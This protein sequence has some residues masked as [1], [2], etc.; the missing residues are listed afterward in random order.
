MDRRR[1]LL[2]RFARSEN[3]FQI[4]INFSEKLDERD[5]S[6]KDERDES[7]VVVLNF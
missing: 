2:L 1:S 6:Q 5:Y 7:Q 3:V 4:A